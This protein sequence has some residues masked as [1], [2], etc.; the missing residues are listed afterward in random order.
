[1]AAVY[2]GNW[3]YGQ[4]LLSDVLITCNACSSANST[5]LQQ[6]DSL[7]SFATTIRHAGSSTPFNSSSEHSQGTGGEEPAHL[8]GPCETLP[9]P[10]CT[11]HDVYT[12]QQL[13]RLCGEEPADSAPGSDMPSDACLRP[14]GNDNGPWVIH[15]QN[16]NCSIEQQA[17]LAGLTRV[18]I[19]QQSIKAVAPRTKAFDSDGALVPQLKVA[20]QTTLMSAGGRGQLVFD[21]NNLANAYAIDNGEWHALMGLWQSEKQCSCL[22]MDWAIIVRL[23]KLASKSHQWLV[24]LALIA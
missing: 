11:I 18:L 3:T 19:L 2:I 7:A 16:D 10:P 13:N 6:D 14:W 8:N 22:Q 9:L 4:V 21:L 1:M 23:L 24:L 12:G 5:G 15:D 17:V 20:Q